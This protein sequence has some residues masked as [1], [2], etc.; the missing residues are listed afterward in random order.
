MKKIV[1]LLI[2]LSFCCS[3]F[4][5]CADK[6]NTENKVA[7][8]SVAL[9]ANTAEI[10]IGE[11][12]SLSCT[13]LPES[14]KAVAVSWKSADESIATVDSSG[15]VIGISEGQTN[16]IA[17]ADN[18]VNDV[19]AI[20]VKELSAYNRMTD[21]EKDFV[22]VML[23]SLQ[24]FKNPK[25]VSVT[26]AY[27]RSATDSWAVTVSAQNS[28]GG[29]TVEDYDLERNGKITKALLPHVKTGLDSNYNL[30]LIN[31]YIFDYTNK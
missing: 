2:I 3:A 16:I 7:V 14:E 29:N 31:E 30:N 1:T 21:R 10:Q 22:D 9:S 25:T 12:I 17:C 24:Y 4:A 26:Y 11:E 19:C 23:K 13:I 8:S 6:K 27:Y 28:M 18:G 5:G 15:K 20:T